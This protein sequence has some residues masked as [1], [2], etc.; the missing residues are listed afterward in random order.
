MD[1]TDAEVFRSVLEAALRS[2][3]PQPVDLLIVGSISE[4]C[5][6]RNNACSGDPVAMAIADSATGQWG[7]LLRRAFYAS[8][9]GS[10]LDRMEFGGGFG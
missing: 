6:E 4:W 8:A 7:V 3:A 5:A 10:I 1:I 2:H 9:V